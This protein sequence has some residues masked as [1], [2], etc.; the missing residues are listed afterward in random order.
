MDSREAAVRHVDII[1]YIPLIRLASCFGLTSTVKIAIYRRSFVGQRIPGKKTL[2]AE[3]MARGIDLLDTDAIHELTNEAGEKISPHMVVKLDAA[4]EPRA[5]FMEMVNRD[6]ARLAMIQCADGARSMNAVDEQL[7]FVLQNIVPIIDSFASTHSILN[8]AWIALSSAYKVSKNQV[9]DDAPIRGLVESLCKLAS[10]ANACPDLLNSRH[11]IEIIDEIGRTSLDIGLI[12]H[13]YTDPSLTGKWPFSV[14]AHVNLLSDMPSQIAECKK[15]CED[16][17]SQ[18]ALSDQLAIN[19]GVLETQYGGHNLQVTGS[20]FNAIGTSGS[21]TMVAGNFINGDYNV[22]QEARGLQ[23]GVDNI[24]GRVKGIQDDQKS[25][26]F[27]Q[28]A[29]VTDALIIPDS[30]EKIEKWISAPDTSLN[31]KTA[32]EKHQQGT[33]S[34]LVEEFAFKEWK[35]LP[36]SILWLHGGPGCGKTILC[37]CAIE[38]V[39]NSLK[40]RASVGYA[41]FFFDGTSAQSKLAAHESLVRSLIIQF[42]DQFDGI[43]PALV[44]LYIEEH[45]GRSQ[46]LITALEATLL[47]IVTSFDASYIVIDAL[48]ECDERSRLLKWIQSITSQTQGLLHLMLTSRPEPGIRDRLRPLVK[49][50][51]INLADQGE[52]GDISHYINVCLSEIDD[53]TEAQ[54]ELVRGAL[55]NGAG[56]VFRWV[57]LMIRELLSDHCL[58]TSELQIRLQSLPKDLNEAYTKIIQRSTRRA[59]VIRFLQWIIFGKQD[60]TARELAEVAS[61]NF[62]A[63][64]NILPFYDSNRRYESPDHVLRACSGLVIEVKVKEFL[65]SKVIPLG[66]TRSIRCNES[67]SHQAIAKTCFAYLLHFGELDSITDE[68]IESFPLAFYAADNC[69]FHVKSIWGEDLDA[70]LE[71]MIQQLASPVVS[72]ALI[73]WYRLENNRSRFGHPTLKSRIELWDDIPA[74]YAAIVTPLTSLV[75]HL[76]TIGECGIALPVTTDLGSLAIAQLLLEKGADI[77]ATGGE[78]G[79]ALQTASYM[80]HLEIARL[81]LEKGAHIN[82]TGGE[83]GT[84]LQTASYMGDLGHL[85]IARLLLEKGAHINATGGEYGTALQVASHE[86]HLEIARLLLE[87]GAD[88]NATGGQYGSALQ[89]TSHR[90]HL[91]IARLLLEKG[92]DI[93]ATGG[94]YGT[95]LQATSHRGHLEIARLLL[96]KGADTNATGGEYGSAL[97]GASRLGYLEI[98][99]LL[100]EKGADINAMGGEYGTALQAASCVGE[101]DIARLLLKKGADFNAVG[102][103]YGTAL[104]A[105]SCVGELDIAR[106]LLK[107]GADINAMGGEYGTALQ[108][109]SYW[110]RLDIARLLLE[111]GADVNATGGYYGTA[112]QAAS[113]RGRVNIA[114]LL[115]DNGADANLTGGEYGTPLQAAAY[116]ENFGIARLLLEKGAEVNVRGGRCGSALQAARDN[117]KHRQVEAIVQLLKEHGALE[118]EPD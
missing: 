116:R 81:L 82:A 62:D 4:I 61:I 110:G 93:N 63:S 76:I 6:M 49:L 36:D 112:L 33:G 14:R 69:V 86:G 97:Q 51:E 55:R 53:W 54:K 47:R 94:Q 56:G 18:L 71:Q 108:A 5:D 27:A 9:L 117:W 48:D 37:S 99:R 57:A 45:N 74:L 64:P 67:I 13:R 52:S 78:Y 24:Q 40:G 7:G 8:L 29:D 19:A 80:G 65:L 16:L 34:W 113:Y 44:E 30:E 83:Y 2:V 114:S 96:E 100:L 41:Y 85:D 109:A 92:A 31:Y 1:L 90:G 73:N 15:R 50:Q 11:T 60:F 79:T 39:K 87:K 17:Q 89:A 88:I 35:E 91:E 22:V 105:A 102:G 42:S 106:L 115:L 38:D 84:A 10:A 103:Y 111:K 104:Q 98:A 23:D 77:N 3:C 66:P 118:M 95:A 58:S 46:P 25:S 43:P 20:T 107:K 101:L 32:R 59:D 75:D 68:N 21:V 70:T 28:S 12:I 26:Y 72:C